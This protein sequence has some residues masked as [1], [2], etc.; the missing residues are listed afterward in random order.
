MLAPPTVRLFVG[1]ANAVTVVAVDEIPDR[2]VA[3][4]SWLIT[5][6]AVHAR[7]L[8][9]DGFAAAGARGYHYRVLAALHEFGAMSQADLARRC[10]MDRSDVVAAVNELAEQGF[11]Q[12]AQDPEDRRRNI[13][14]LTPPGGRQLR[15]LDRALDKVQDDLLGPLSSADRQTLTSLLAR[16]LTHH[17]AG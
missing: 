8:V 17:A 5:Q 16:L 2:L 13:V 11:V 14:T 15:R 6:L 12:R 3:K 10:G 7:R 9:F 1:R 4:P